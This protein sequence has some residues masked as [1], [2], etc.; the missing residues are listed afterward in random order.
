MG[1]GDDAAVLAWRRGWRLLLTAD[2]S[3][4]GVHFDT[5]LH[6]PESVGHRALARSLSDIAA[7]GG[8]PRVALVSLALSSRMTRRWVERFYAGLLALA[9]RFRV[10]I[11]GGDTARTPGQSLVDVVVAGEALARNILLR[12][13]AQAGDRLYVAGELGAAALGLHLLRA[14]AGRNSRALRPHLYPEP[15]CKIGRYLAA[16]RLASAAMDLSDGLSTDLARLCAASDVGARVRTDQLPLARFL[17]TRNSHG[18][19]PLSLALHGGED[20]KLLFSVP[21]SKAS[22]L[23]AAIGGVRLH[24]IGEVTA[25]RAIILISADGVE[26]PLAPG[27]Y[28]HFEKR[29]SVKEEAALRSHLAR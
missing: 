17:P 9:R 5:C 15:Q 25:S 22:L 21:A 13:G 4:E 10:E 23:P 1:V 2:L 16:R 14:G 29:Y 28:D 27:G 3:I 24:E 19:S 26:R 8:A 20:Y 12:S 7:M 11:A 18:P 6:P